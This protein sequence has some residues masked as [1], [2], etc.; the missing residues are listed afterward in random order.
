MKEPAH[1]S[2][3]RINH[4]DVDDFFYLQIVCGGADYRRMMP[5]VQKCIDETL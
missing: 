1:R 3:L 5:Y 2:S 4:E